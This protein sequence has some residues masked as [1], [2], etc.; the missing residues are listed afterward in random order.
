MPERAGVIEI[1]RYFLDFK[2]NQTGKSIVL[3]LIG[4]VCLGWIASTVYGLFNILSRG[5]LGLLGA[6]KLLDDWNW[7][8]RVALLDV[9]LSLVAFSGIYWLMKRH[10]RPS[11]TQSKK[12]LFETP[13]PH[14]GLIFLLSPY[15]PRE[16][17]FGAVDRIYLDDE[18]AREHLLKS[19]WGPLV[20]AVQHHAQS[21]SLKHCWLICTKGATGSAL[22]FDKA[23]ELIKHFVSK[24]VKCHIREIASMN[25]VGNVAQVVE[26]IYEK[27]PLGENLQPDQIIAD[28]TGGTAAMSGGLIIA[29]LLK[30]RHVQYFSQDPDK[31]IFKKDG[32]AFTPQEIAET[33]ALITVV[34]STSDRHPE[35]LD[36]GVED[37]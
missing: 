27:A 35:P 21:S 14:D 28:F 3:F 30:D 37:E 29:T 36:S 31:P 10:L 13:A 26:E 18:K 12:I 17:I 33:N 20:V 19:N 7:S 1:L 6:T 34:I 4:I 25:D 23:K 22:Q 2:R 32:R 5:L 15:K 8:L 9:A 11:S 16:S 24:K